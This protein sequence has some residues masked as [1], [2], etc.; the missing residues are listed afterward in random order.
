MLSFRSHIVK[1]ARELNLK[2]QVVAELRYDLPS[3]YKFHKKSS[4]DIAVDFWRF[5]LLKDAVS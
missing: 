4:V 5:E 1:K 2:S 3:S